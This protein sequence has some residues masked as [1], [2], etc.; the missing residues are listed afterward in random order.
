M[1]AVRRSS[2]RD[3]RRCSDGV[4]RTCFARWVLRSRIDSGNVAFGTTRR[5][6]GRDWWGPATEDSPR[7]RRRRYRTQRQIGP[8]FPVTLQSRRSARGGECWT[9]AASTARATDRQ[10]EGTARRAPRVG[11][12]MRVALGSS[13]A[14]DLATELLVRLLRGKRIDARHFSRE[15]ARC[16]AGTWRKPRRRFDRFLGER[17]PQ[18]WNAKSADLISQQLRCC[19][20]KQTS[21][22]VLCPGVTAPSESRQQRRR[23]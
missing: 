7:H 17:F 6:G 13:P 10:M 20:R 4:S 18:L 11:R 8:E 21:S 9:L 12:H 1:G 19:C 23:S 2:A 5:R 15:V 16:R 14:D 3:H 22:R